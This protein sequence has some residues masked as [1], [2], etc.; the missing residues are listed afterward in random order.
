MNPLNLRQIQSV[1][2]AERIARKIRARQLQ[3]DVFHPCS[4]RCAVVPRDCQWLQQ[5]TFDLGQ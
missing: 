5:W 4:S 2:S 3:V 1:A